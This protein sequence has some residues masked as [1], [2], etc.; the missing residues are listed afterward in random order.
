[1]K[2]LKYIFIAGLML[3]VVGCSTSTESVAP[4]DK[5]S[6]VKEVAEIVNTATPLPPATATSVPP[7]ATPA[8]EPNATLV[9]PTSTPIL[10]A[11]VTSSYTPTSTPM[12]TTIIE[13]ID[14]EEI[15]D[16]DLRKRCEMAKRMGFSDEDIISMATDM[17]LDM[18]LLNNQGIEE[19]NKLKTSRRGTSSIDITDPRCLEVAEEYRL[20]CEES[21]RREVKDGTEDNQSFGSIDQESTSKN[22]NESSTTSQNQYQGKYDNT[23]MPKLHNLGIKNL[24]PYD[25]VN[26]MFGDLLFDT[27]LTLPI[28]IEFGARMDS[29]QAKGYD[30]PTFE[31][32]AP[33]D[34][35]VISPIDGVITNLDWQPSA[36]YVQ[37]D[38][39]VIISPS[40]HSSWGVSIDHVVSI[41]CDRKGYI[42]VYC[43]KPLQINNINLELGTEVKIGDVIGYVGNWMENG[44][45]IN[46][47]TEITL[48]QYIENLETFVIDTV[49]YCPTLNLAESVESSLKDAVVNLMGKYEMVHG[50]DSAY[51]ESQMVAPGCIYS[52][53]E[54]NETGGKSIK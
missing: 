54:E 16:L 40:M 35:L 13:T 26:R 27:S 17:G 4:T 7:T 33:A 36:G 18:A 44:T 43:D 6:L 11:T 48:F 9:P 29:G 41:N 14:C 42:P 31:F 24:G 46:G 28:F 1:M 5:V 39:E 22:E 53:I 12:P 3:L 32:T 19:D 8:P 45:K 25:D 52:T 15:N 23:T 10:T 38:W 47:R 51:D 49:S 34:T 20:T 21:L 37:D 30:N 50:R 2:Y